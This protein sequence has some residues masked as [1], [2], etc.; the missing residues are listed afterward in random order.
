MDWDINQIKDT[1]GVEETGTLPG[2]SSHWESHYFPT[3]LVEARGKRDI[4]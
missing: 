2:S 4:S 1:V 3:T